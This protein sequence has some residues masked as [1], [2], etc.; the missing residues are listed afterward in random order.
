[1]EHS[2][3]DI[4]IIGMAGRFP[5]ADSVEQFWINLKEGRDCITRSPELDRDGYVA[6]Y[7]KMDDIGGFDAA[8]FHI[9]DADAARMDHEQRIMMELTYHAL[10][11]AGYDSLSW[12]GRIG[13]WTS[14][15]G[16]V[17]VWNRIMRDPDWFSSYEL[18]KGYITTRTERIAYQFGFRGPA[19]ESEYSCASSIQAV[20]AA[21]EALLNYDCDMALA[22]GI[23]A[24]PIQTGYPSHLATESSSG[25]IRPFD[26]DA[27]GLVPGSAAGILVL[28]RYE[29]ARGDHDSVAAVIK[30][31]FVNNDGR[32]KAGFAAPGVAGQTDCLKSVLA[33]AETGRSGI[34][35]YE[36]H[37]TGTELGDAVE[38]R[39]ICSVLREPQPGIKV[40][41]GSV[42]SN[43]GHTNMAAG[44]CNLIKTALILK[45]RTFVPSLHYQNPCRE[46]EDPACPLAVSVRT[47]R[48]DGSRPMTAVASA[49]GIGGANAMAVLQEDLSD[50]FA[51]KTAAE[52]GGSQLLLFSGHTAQAVRT[53]ADE[54]IRYIREHAV[55]YDDAAYT[56]QTGRH[57]FA[58]RTFRI[59][60]SRQNRPRAGRVFQIRDKKAPRLIFMFSGAGSLK[61]DAG[62]GLYETDAIFRNYMDQ[63]FAVCKEQGSGDVKNA[64]LHFDRDH[65][66]HF[67]E[68]GTG[69]LVLFSI[70]YSLA[71][72]FEAYGIIPEIVIGHSNGEY[73]AAAFCGLLDPGAAVR[74]LIQREALC[75]DLPEGGMLQI[76]AGEEKVRALLP[77]GT[78]IGAYNAEDRLMVS[79]TKEGI[80]DLEQTLRKHRIVFERVPVRRSAHSSQ[81]DPVIRPFEEAISG[82]G[83]HKPR[84]KFLSTAFPET[85]DSRVFADPSYW[86]EQMR[87]P[88]HFRERVVGLCSS[89]ED[90]SLFLEIG[91]GDSLST[92]ARRIHPAGKPA[93]QAVSAFD[94]PVA[95]DSRDGFLSALGELWSRG[96]TASFEKLYRKQPYKVPLA[97]Y[98]FEHKTYWDFQRRI[99]PAQSGSGE[100]FLI[101]GGLS[102]EF[103]ERTRY[104]GGTGV[105]V[106]L[107]EPEEERYHDNSDLL[108]IREETEI[109]K[110]TELKYFSDP[111]EV[112][113]LFRDE[114]YRKAADRLSAACIL[115]YIFSIP[116]IAADRPF[117]EEQLAV[118]G[119]VVE[120][121]RP[122]LHYFICFLKDYGYLEDSF[123]VL[124]FTRKASELPSRDQVLEEGKKAFPD[125]CG[126]ME[127]C[128]LCADHYPEVFTGK[129]PGSTVIYEDG[130]FRRIEKYEAKMP[131]CSYSETCLKAL[132]FLTA[133]QVRQAGRKVRILEIGAGAGRLTK[134]TETALGEEEA[135][136]WFTDLK[137]SFVQGW[138]QRAEQRKGRVFRYRQ[139]D[140]S[141]DPEEQGFVPG[142]FDLIILYDVLQAAADLKNAVHN[143]RRLL[144]DDGIFSFVQTCD[145][146]ELENMIYGYAPGWWN[147]QKDPQRTRITLPPERWRALLEEEGFR[148]IVRLPE[149]GRSDVYLFTMRAPYASGQGRIFCREKWEE[150][151]QVLKKETSGKALQIF[152]DDDSEEARRTLAEKLNCTQILKPEADPGPDAETAKWDDCRND[153]DRAVAEIVAEACGKKIS[154]SEDLYDFGMDSLTLMM[155]ASK[156]QTKLG[157]QLELRDLYGFRSIREISDYL[158]EDAE[159]AENVSAEPAAEPG[160]TVGDL[161]REIQ[162]E[163]V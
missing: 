113:E 4:A 87:V 94:S 132:A 82:I 29:D 122:F 57:P 133:E 117:T 100:R 97:P 74:M 149:N 62:R 137:Q 107:V 162:D 129:R 123:G 19:V 54:N 51:E 64:F 61:G 110:R 22:G 101:A 30:A 15:N 118:S 90:T 114:K 83:F 93:V 157:L 24:E 115:N 144:A 158:S 14:F 139:L 23:T 85:A 63:C 52:N 155:I 109:Q 42:K 159:K 153:M 46:L 10:E 50:R 91:T 127:F 26:R 105:P 125:C 98:P 151:Y 75:A 126:H 16:G 47:E 108:S 89:K 38:L 140:I 20:H 5:K 124:K 120:P 111:A 33:A 138:R 103:W 80:T 134:L 135:E 163:T 45:N 121:W 71:K 81:L 65:A 55:R 102:D 31:T 8:F 145:G 136:Y 3:Y 6:A 77:G 34:D 119:K 21:C 161:L 84:M 78:E 130:T 1:M 58:W 96:I 147:Y 66:E 25:C 27:D 76:A 49:V 104:I 112:R 68:E 79:G 59:I 86:A 13:T 156:V 141:R 60:G 73:T 2:E 67:T 152:T 53:A 160:R 92:A 37:G 11:N 36:A 150:R 39:A 70:G 56:L 17:Y 106:W 148:R 32:D 143:V 48:W 41:I 18:Q 9:S 69:L 88:V 146:V 28:K 40:R 72:T 12:E 154:I 99:T 35:Y 44:I 142:S 7:G 131:V 128:V 43:I 95:S 116:G